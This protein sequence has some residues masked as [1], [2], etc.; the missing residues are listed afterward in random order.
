MF[1]CEWKGSSRLKCSDH[2]WLSLPSSINDS[3]VRS[4]SEIYSQ[5][6]SLVSLRLLQQTTTD[7]NIDAPKYKVSCAR[8]C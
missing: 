1:V 6:K 4:T 2:P 7:D 8:L 5:I 3:R